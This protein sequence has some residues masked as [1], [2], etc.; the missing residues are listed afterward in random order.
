MASEP[1]KQIVISQFSSLALNPNN[2]I[3]VGVDYGTTFTGAS[4]VSSKGNGLSDIT[5]IETWPGISRDSN[6]VTK[7]PSRISYPDGLPNQWGYQVQPGANAYSWTKLLLD[8][9]APLTRYDDEGLEKASEMG[10]LRLP[11]GK[12]ASD[13]VRDYLSEVYQHILG[14]I[15][16]QI[17]EETLK[18]T[19]LEFWFTVPAIWSDQAQNATINAARKAGFGNRASRPDDEI[20]LIS[21]P[22]AAAITSL[23][24]YTTKGIGNFIKPGDGVLICDCGG[25]TVDMTTYLVLQTLPYLTFEELC[26]GNGGKCGSTA[27]D[28]NFYQ[29]MSDRF[30]DAFDKLPMKKKSPGSEF[31]S[32]FEVIKQDFGYPNQ[33]KIF[34]IHLNMNAPN[35]D[36]KYFDEEERMVFLSSED[37]RSIFDPVV[38][39]ILAMV[40]QQI[41]DSQEET[42]NRINRIILVGGF[43]D[44]EYLRKAFRESFEPMDIN[45]TVPDKPQAAIVQGAA[46]RGLEGLRSSTKRCR[47]HYGFSWSTDFREG[48]DIESESYIDSFTGLK[49]SSNMMKWM[50][51]KGE[52]YS[53]NHTYETWVRR[54][55]YESYS[56]KKKT[57]LYACDLSD[58]PERRGSNIYHVGDIEV[59]FSHTD[60]NGFSSKYIDGQKAYLLTYK[61]KVIF[62]A[63]EG[64]LKFEATSQG[65]TIGRTS[66]KF[67]TIR[68]Y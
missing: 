53:E 19:P 57:V 4:F 17:T 43:G 20:Y 14:R 28:R 61:L 40:R 65:E 37:L 62:G 12:T 38:E 15:A 29:L 9:S 25:G 2:K 11:E 63:Q 36:P 24:K 21:E 23:K 6:T 34:E 67:N 47:R 13:V 58:A 27:V 22:E 8:Q 35:A 32:K 60:L 44:S 41:Q 7:V 64:V 49:M 52:K 16:K 33:P 46:L 1:E 31:M 68:Y 45:I 3:I 51:A 42:G 48:V 50:I 10:I 5:V 56:L 59:D 39:R 30:G 18:T 54:T 66:I 55:H 26:T